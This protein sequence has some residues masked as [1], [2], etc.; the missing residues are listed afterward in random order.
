LLENQSKINLDDFKKRPSIVAHSFGTYLVANCMLKHRDV[1]FDKII[2]C[3]S[4][5]PEDFDWSILF[6]RDQV[7]CVRNEC[8]HKDVWPG[9]ARKVVPGTGNSGQNG[10]TFRSTNFKQEHFDEFE[11]SDALVLQHMRTEWFPFLTQPPSGLIVRN[12]RDF[13]R[14]KKLSNTLD[15]THEIDLKHYKSLPHTLKSTSREA[16]Q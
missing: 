12:G 8:G 6:G 5:L 15:D 2:L 9:I 14:L 3:G 13:D 4:I 7:N 16:S 11:H 1:K 10:F